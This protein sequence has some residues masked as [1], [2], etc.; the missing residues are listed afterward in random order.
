MKWEGDSCDLIVLDFVCIQ[1]LLGAG[2]HHA[3]PVC[4]GP[5]NTGCGDE[6]NTLHVLTLGGLVPQ[7]VGN[8]KTG[9]QAEPQNL[10]R[11]CLLDAELGWPGGDGMLL[12]PCG[13]QSI[14]EELINLEKPLGRGVGV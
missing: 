2:D 4:W 3:F 5:G 8:P 12:F 14:P 7:R 1:G 9:P 11:H 13:C 10:G 6:R